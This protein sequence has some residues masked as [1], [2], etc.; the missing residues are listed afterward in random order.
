M[1]I[2]VASKEERVRLRDEVIGIRTT[3]SG[4]TEEIR[5]TVPVP[6]YRVRAADGQSYLVAQDQYRAA[7]PGQPLQVCR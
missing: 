7:G 1:T 6:E 3:E 2:V 5:R 4:R